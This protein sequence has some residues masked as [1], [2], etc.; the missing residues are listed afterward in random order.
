M[1]WNL[2]LSIVRGRTTDDLAA[3]GS[4]L[5]MFG[6]A[7]DPITAEEATGLPSP[8]VAQAA[9]DVLFID[10]ALIATQFNTVLAAK[11]GAEVVTG[12]FSDVTDTYL[13]SVLHPDGGH[14]TDTVADEG[15]LF[16]LLEKHTGLD[17]DWLDL[18]AY[19]LVGA[20]TPPRTR[21]PL[22]R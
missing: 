4:S 9:D 2:H 14:R 1:G 7:D 22:R 5:G 13:W 8:A 16:G 6:L 21:G 17:A 18:P 19:P 15:T 12:I 10:G 20:S 3:L 11:L